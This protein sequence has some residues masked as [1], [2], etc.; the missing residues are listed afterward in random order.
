MSQDADVDE[1]SENEMAAK[2]KPWMGPFARSFIGR[3]GLDFPS[4]SFDA[5]GTQAP[6]SVM[7]TIIRPVGAGTPAK[8]YPAR[9][10]SH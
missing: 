2:K 7:S 5:Q 4:A 8:P 6:T 3:T 10:Q 9:G 1:N